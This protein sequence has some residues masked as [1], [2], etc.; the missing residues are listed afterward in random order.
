MQA[1]EPPPP[2]T[3][4]EMP[5]CVHVTWDSLEGVCQILRVSTPSEPQCG[6]FV[7]EPQKLHCIA[8]ACWLYLGHPRGQ[9]GSW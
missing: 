8:P 7:V 5:E 2:L 3:V 9:L 6:V 4:A 1:G